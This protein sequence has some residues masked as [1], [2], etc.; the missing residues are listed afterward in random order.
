MR[1]RIISGLSK[2][3]FV[4]E[5]KERSGTLITAQAAIEQGRDVFALPGNIV[6]SHSIGTNL[7]I[8]D[9]AKLVL[10]AKDIEEEYD[11]FYE[12]LRSVNTIYAKQTY[13]F[14]RSKL[15]KIRNFFEFYN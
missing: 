14:I 9:G 6:S 8:Q 13:L 4:V 11:L 12:Y 7:L 10:S 3:L 15:N 1:N 2:A 5:A